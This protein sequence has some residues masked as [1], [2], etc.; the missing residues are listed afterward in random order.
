MITSSWLMS[1]AA[2][3]LGCILTEVRWILRMR[4]LQGQLGLRDASR[5]NESER[6][7][8]F[9]S[10]EAAAESPR[11]FETLESLRNLGHELA[12]NA[13]VSPVPESLTTLRS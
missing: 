5:E 7:H 2:F 11:A 10:G 3:T 1:V 9:A 4:R 12:K 13:P 8:L 6:L